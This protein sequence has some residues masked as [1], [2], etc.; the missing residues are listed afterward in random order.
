MALISNAAKE[1]AA[2]VIACSYLFRSLGSAIG[3][4]V[5]SAILQQVLRSQLAVQLGNG[6]DAHEIE[7]RVRESLDYI[8]QLPPGTA[9][10]VR[11]CY[12]TA[13]V[14]VFG[15]QALPTALAFVSSFFIREKK[16]G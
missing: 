7:E 10:I 2:V 16:L 6:Q 1:D 13:T 15:F 4:S 14:V 11:R 5:A 8:S 12:Q 3:V 9:E